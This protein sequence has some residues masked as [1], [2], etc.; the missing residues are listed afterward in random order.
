MDLDKTVF[1]FQKLIEQLRGEC[2]WDKQ[3]THKSLK[4]HLLEEAYEVLEAIDRLE[5]SASRENYSALKDELGDLLYQVFFHSLLASEAGE[6]SVE[7]VVAAIHEKLYRRH[8]HIFGDL[9]IQTTEELAPHWEE[10]K[11]AEKSTDSVMDKLPEALPALLLAAKIQRKAKALGFGSHASE[12]AAIKDIKSSLKKLEELGGGENQ[13]DASE[14]QQQALEDQQ[15]ALGELLWAAAYLAM[16]KDIDAE[17][18]LR[19]SA[20]A[21]AEEVRLKEL[22][23]DESNHS[24]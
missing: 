21:F 1:E 14:D 18:V 11:K 6:F 8:P 19:Q 5:A 16:K 23:P 12:P 4:R 10:M 15:Q 13:T 2:P 22:K 7:D 3:Q 17:D 9:D 20:R 24:N